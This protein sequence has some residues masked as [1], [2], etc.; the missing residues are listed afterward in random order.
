MLWDKVIAI[1]GCHLALRQ[2][3]TDGN[4]VVI[5]KTSFVTSHFQTESNLK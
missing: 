1:Q 2:P 4:S 5:L 3:A